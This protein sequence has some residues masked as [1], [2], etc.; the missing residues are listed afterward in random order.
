MNP[1]QGFG[2]ARVSDGRLVM[3]EWQGRRRPRLDVIRE[4]FA[5]GM[6]VADIAR[7]LGVKYQIV[8]MAVRGHARPATAD[9]RGDPISTLAEP[10]A[11][12]VGCVSQKN[13]DPAPAKDLYR[14][15]LFRRRR[16]WAE[17]S[18]RPWWIVSAEYGLVAPDEVIAPYDTRI[19]A[20]SAADRARLARGVAERLESEI[21]PLRAKVLELHAGD[22]YFLAVAPELR[23]RGAA[24]VRPLEGLRIGEQLGWYGDHLHLEPTTGGAQVRR[25]PARSAASM[26]G[27][28]RG[29]SH[30]ITKL[31]VS[32]GLDLSSRRGAPASGWDGMPEVVA[33][34]RLRQLGASEAE[35]RLFLTFAAAMD[36]AR[37]ADVLARRAVRMF[38]AA[39]WT[40][41]PDEISRRTLRDLTDAL[42]EFGVSQRHSVDVFGW[43][44]LAETLNDPSV[45]PES[46]AAIHQGQA[47]ARRL[48]AELA[49]TSKQGTPLFPLLSGPKVSALW[50][51]LLAF[52]G[53]AT[54]TSMETVPVAVDVQVRKVTEYLAVTDTGDLDLIDARSPIQETWARDVDGH[55]AAG[56]EAVANTPGALDPALWFYAK[57]GCTFCENAGRKLPISPICGDCRFPA[58]SAGAGP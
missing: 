2:R 7:R 46:R 49:S 51:R 6:P 40:F 29:L 9:R 53:G 50:V 33:T 42:K 10:D 5:A 21:G 47:D 17:A 37:D 39:P 28:G 48:T 3:I 57:W 22:E 4:L 36:R 16:L 27:N 8:Y 30:V 18:K 19:A 31:F 41:A 34:S 24:V 32:G 43:R 15:E 55:G 13:T 44:T 35:L 26:I 14:S 1:T 58:R 45:A 20:L 25:R 11:I 52:P 38:E 23:R 56:P 54:I 12:L